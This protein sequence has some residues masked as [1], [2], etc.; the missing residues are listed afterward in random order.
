[1][2]SNNDRKRAASS[3][4]AVKKQRVSIG[5]QPTAYFDP[6]GPEMETDDD[7]DDFTTDDCVS[8]EFESDEDDSSS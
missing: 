6:E 7:D 5:S 1:M 3:Y 4:V 8:E 2:S